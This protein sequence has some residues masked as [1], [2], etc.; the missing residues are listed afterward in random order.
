MAAKPATQ[1]SAQ[2]WLEQG[3]KTLAASGFTALRAEPLAKLMGVSRGSFYWHFADV[4]AFHKALLELWRNV[5]VDQIVADIEEASSGTNPLPLLMSRAFS[6]RQKLEIAI[7]SWAS[8][9]PLVRKALQ[10]VDERRQLFIASWLEEAG[11]APD[12]AR[13]RAQILYWAFVGYTLSET[14]PSRSRRAAIL[15]EL[16]RLAS[17]GS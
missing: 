13:A 10:A 1:L 9:S 5:A 3:L 15:E 2:D 6:G 12:Q 16:I 7:R 17:P 11:F 4:E 14:A 8:H